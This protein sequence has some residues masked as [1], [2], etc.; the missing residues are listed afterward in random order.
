V[1]CVLEVLRHSEAIHSKLTEQF[2]GELLDYLNKTA[3]ISVRRKLVWDR[4][5]WLR[6]KWDCV[7]LD[8]EMLQFKDCP[9][10]LLYRIE[11]YTSPKG[12][13][14]YYGLHWKKPTR[15]SSKFF[16]AKPILNL[17]HLLEFEDY[18]LTDKQWWFGWRYLRK[19][20]S[21]EDFLLFFVE[22]R[23]FLFQTVGE[24][25]WPLVERTFNYVEK[26]NRW[27]RDHHVK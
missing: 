14:L 3:P 19:F 12:I 25:F 27:F 17:R 2:W 7:Y 9:Q 23:K 21:T 11:Y 5:T 24:G 16:S 22:N 20:T 8:A 4:D 18:E 15:A 6:T 13:H 10:R 1:G 26:A